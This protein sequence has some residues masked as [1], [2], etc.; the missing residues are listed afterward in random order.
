MGQNEL[1]GSCLLVIFT[2]KVSVWWKVGLSC[3]TEP[4]MPLS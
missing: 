1:H 2:V 3:Q 4:A